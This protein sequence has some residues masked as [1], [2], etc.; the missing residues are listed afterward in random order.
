MG[1]IDTIKR[2]LRY[3]RTWGTPVG[4][5]CISLDTALCRWLGE[6]L[7]F[8]AQHGNSAPYGYGGTDNIEVSLNF[9]EFHLSL[10]SASL[11][12]WA[13]RYN[14]S[15]TAEEDASHYADAQEA[16]RWVAD[17]LGTLWD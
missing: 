6:R 13:D 16:M 5:D 17:N 2:K 12:R 7:S 9:Y 11:L 10:H 15:W 1:I 8:L 3:R 4:Q 14:E